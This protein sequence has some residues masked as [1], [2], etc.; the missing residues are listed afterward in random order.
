MHN[1]YIIFTNNKV[2]KYGLVLKGDIDEEM[3]EGDTSTILVKV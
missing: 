2:Y 3:R 1:F